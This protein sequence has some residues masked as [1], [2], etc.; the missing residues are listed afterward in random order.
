MFLYRLAGRVYGRLVLGVLAASCVLNVSA[1]EPIP[2]LVEALEDIAFYPMYSAPAEVMS[3]NDSRLS[4]EVQAV[5]KSIPVKV[6]Q[7]VARGSVLVEL[8][9][10]DY[11][12][13]LQQAK[14]VLSAAKD[15]TIFSAQ[16]QKRAE[17]L[18]NTSNISE[19]LALQ[20]Q[21]NLSNAKA[22]EAVAVAALDRARL[23]VA[24]CVIRAPFQGV[25]LERLAGV[26][27]TALPT[28][29]LIRL[30]DSEAMEV[31]AQVSIDDAIDLAHATDLTFITENMK[32]Q[33]KLARITESVNSRAR[34]R[35][36]RLNFSQTAALPG[37]P[38]RLTWATTVPHVAA[39]LLATLQGQVGVFTVENDKAKFIALPTAL[40]GRPIAI[41]LPL[42]S[43]VIVEG[44]RLV[45]DG[46]AV[47]VKP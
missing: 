27:E 16:Q 35:E 12:L 45:V 10:R 41:D 17:S 1:D 23:D 33:L 14:A 25:V 43:K 31:S 13:N 44:Q 30:L 4:A 19:E 9:C 22:E 18:R 36:A 29:P 24:R 38:G 37:T 20:R 7:S 3:L 32:Y 46:R 26:G 39:D 8:D 5:I 34:S 11:Q 15:R 2:V 42:S 21:T 47:E 28:T 40:E 6:G